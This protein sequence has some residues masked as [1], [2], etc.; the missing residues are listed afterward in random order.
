M[1]RRT[2]RSAMIGGIATGAVAAAMLPG[3]VSACL[4]RS[5]PRRTSTELHGR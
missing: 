4:C 1:S 5:R 2:L 3:S